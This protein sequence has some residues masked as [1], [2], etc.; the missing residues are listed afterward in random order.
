VVQQRV[1]EV[2]SIP[3]KPFEGVHAPAGR[4]GTTAWGPT[5]SSGPGA[6]ARSRLQAVICPIVSTPRSEPARSTTMPACTSC[7]SRS[8]RRPSGPCGDQGRGRTGPPCRRGA[9][10]RAGSGQPASSPPAGPRRR[11]GARA[12][13]GC[14]GSQSARAVPD[15]RPWA[16]PG[17]I[18]L[19][20]Q[21]RGHRPGG[22]G[23]L[24]C[25]RDGQG[26]GSARS[27]MEDSS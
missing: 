25:R 15:R 7:S 17:T 16:P 2:V 27:L 3:G 11:G 19:P 21:A 18:S 24:G 14:P 5:R 6:P 8:D 20:G 9:R 26:S 12:P 23:A 4:A 22:V 10:H 1:R 13:Q